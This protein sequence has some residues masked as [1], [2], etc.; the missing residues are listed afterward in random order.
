MRRLGTLGTERLDW[1]DP[2]RRERVIL[3]LGPREMREVGAELMTFLAAG[4]ALATLTPESA[5]G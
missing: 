4:E 3:V 1:K 5:I 2:G